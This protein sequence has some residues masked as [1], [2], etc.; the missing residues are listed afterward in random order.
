MVKTDYDPGE[1]EPELKPVAKKAG[2][3]TAGQGTST[4]AKSSSE[5][6]PAPLSGPHRG[7][8]NGAA[9]GTARG[10]ANG[11]GSAKRPGSTR[12]RVTGELEATSI[13]SA[14]EQFAT[15][16]EDAPSCDRCGA[17]TVRNGNCYLCYN[18]GNSM[19]CS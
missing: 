6:P 3:P 16:Q 9:N 11:K 8:A 5:T 18:C 7:P 15:F 2:G 10:A 1:S 12:N 19:G 17:I 14:N 4:P 13:T